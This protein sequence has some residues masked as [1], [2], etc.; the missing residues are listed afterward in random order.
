MADWLDYAA[1][2]LL[3]LLVGAGELISRYKDAPKQ[4]LYTG[5][6]L[7]Y[8][9]LNLAASI[10]ALALI[11][12]FSWTFNT[13]GPSQR[14]T[15]VLVAGVGAMAFFRTS[16]FTVRAGD[17][18]LGVGPG[19]FLEIFRAS[20]DRAVDRLRA[21]ARSQC[22]AQLMD[23]IDYNKA[24]TGLVP[25]CLALMQNVPDE[26]QKKLADEL[27]L[28][29]LEPMDDAIKVRVLG[30]ALLNVVGP[31]VLTAAVGGLRDRMQAMDAAPAQPTSPPLL[32]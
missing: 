11:R 29:D 17:R 10:L 18:D 14:W 6:A 9:A 21:G 8:I 7:L 23:G 25:Y 28:L 24:K 26:D 13:T 30:L 15:Q 5:P 1:V 3:G 31:G 32:P 19:T 16:F 12:G 2:A 27:K 4:A 20:A 22:V